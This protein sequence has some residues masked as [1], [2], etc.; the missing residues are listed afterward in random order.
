MFERIPCNLEQLDDNQDLNEN[1]PNPIT[2]TTLLNLNRKTN[3][4]PFELFTEISSQMLNVL[5]LTITACLVNASGN[6]LEP[7]DAREATMPWAI[8]QTSLETTKTK[9][10]RIV[11]SVHNDESTVTGL[12]ITAG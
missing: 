2:S 6:G 4:K 1:K 8:P 12:R 7:V 3:S 5:S 9:S 11:E 10:I